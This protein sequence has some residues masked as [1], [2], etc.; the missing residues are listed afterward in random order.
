MSADF[1]E[2]QFPPQISYGAAGGPGFN[3]DVTTSF[4]GW[5]NRNQNWSV[6]RIKYDASTGLKDQSDLD[7]LLAF[8]YARA[9]K[10]RGFRFK[11]WGDYQANHAAANGTQ[12]VLSGTADGTNKVFQLKKTYTSGSLTYSRTIAK[13]ANL[14][15]WETP[16]NHS[17]GTPGT[18]VTVYIGGVKQASSGFSV[19]YTTGLITFVTAPLS[20][21]VLTADFEFDV[22]ARFDTDELKNTIEAFDTNHW[23]SIPIVEVRI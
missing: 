2:V 1:D 15:T 8:F 16:I 19:D 21:S 14:G 18:P 4:G 13:P 3:T 12:G 6:A 23:D 17:D 22:P 20:G 9:G 5:E 7:A 11:D 10:A